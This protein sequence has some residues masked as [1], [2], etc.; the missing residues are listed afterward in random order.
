MGLFASLPAEMLIARYANDQSKF[1]DVGG[2]R[3]H[4]RDQGNPDGIPLVLIHGSTARCTC[5]RAGCARSA[6]RR[7]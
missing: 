1:I 6:G 4:V 3:A 2:V 7:G 5:G